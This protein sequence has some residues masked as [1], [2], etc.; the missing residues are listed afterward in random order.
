VKRLPGDS[1]TF[2]TI[3]VSCARTRTG[4]S[5]GQAQVRAVRR[6]R[7]ERPA[8]R[9][10]PSTLVYLN[11]HFHR[12]SRNPLD[13]GDPRRHDRARRPG[14]VPQACRAPYD[15]TAGLLSVR[16]GAT[17][18]DAR[19][20][21]TKGAPDP[22]LR[23][24]PRSVRATPRDRSGRGAPPGWR[25]SWTALRP[26][27]T[28]WSRLGSRDRGPDEL[29]RGPRQGTRRPSPDAAPPREGPRLRRD[30]PVTDP[31]KA[32]RQG[33]SHRRAHPSRRRAPRCHRGQ[34]PPSRGTSRPRWG[35][36][37]RRRLTGDE[38]RTLGHQA[39]SPAPRR[40]TIFRP[41]SIPTRSSR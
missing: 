15:F 36:T 6:D 37:V 10:G 5:P 26:T 38:M 24:R 32:G 14:R 9:R 28:A 18:P 31:A 39:W 21:V 27:A 3:T 41:A 20:L 11:S 7:K 35:L 16:G 29:A 4:R 33:G 40:T 30:H 25:R 12:A 34:R 13:T 1:R 2:G 22:F 19:W 17:G 8:R 23:A